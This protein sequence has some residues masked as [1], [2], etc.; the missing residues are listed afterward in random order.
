MPDDLCVPEPGE[1]LDRLYRDHKTRLH[2]LVSRRLSDPSHAEDVT[3]EAFTRL[4]ARADLAELANP[5]AMLTRIAINIIR[6]GFRAERY[7]AGR[8]P[9][10]REHFVTT[11]PVPDPENHTASRQE[12]AR[13]R[14]AIDRLPPRCREVFIMH[15]I[16]GLSHS[17][18][19]RTLGI[20]RNM[21]EKHVIRAYTQLREHRDG[22]DT[23]N[24]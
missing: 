11:R 17:D 20:S 18:V 7:R 13:L 22:C 1:S 10:L 24:D 14:D 8:E 16:H 23:R 2:R 12:L 4:A 9:E 5:L 15:K 19:A 3:H 21:V 6:D